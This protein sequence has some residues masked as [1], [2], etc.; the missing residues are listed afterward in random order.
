MKL[1]EKTPKVVQVRVTENEKTMYEEL[2]DKDVD[3]PYMIR[4]FIRKLHEQVI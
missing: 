3:M 1:K 2:M 4:E